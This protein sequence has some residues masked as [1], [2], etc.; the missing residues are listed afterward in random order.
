MIHKRRLAV[1]LGVCVAASSVAYAAPG[2]GQKD[3]SGGVVML[4]AGARTP[5]QGY[6]GV[7]IRDVGEEQVSALHLKD[8]RGAEIV[9]VDH[10]GPAGKAGL[11][12]RDVILQMNGQ[13]VEGA[14]PLR[15]MLRATT[16]GRV[17][18]FVICRDGQQQTL[19]A[20]LADR[21]VVER[22]AWEQHTTVPEPPQESDFA[23]FASGFFSAAQAQA[24]AGGGR[25]QNNLIATT[26]LSPS[27]T[28][29]ILETM[30]PQLAEFFGATGGAGLLVRSVDA[31]SPAAAAGM[32]A[33]DVVVRV[34]STPIA[35]GNDW[36]RTMHDSLGKTV[37]VVVLRDKREQTLTL[38]PDGKKRSAMEWEQS[39][40]ADDGALALSALLPLLQVDL[41][42]NQ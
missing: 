23:G 12:E 20:K 29:A 42:F 13:P 35:N 18:S 25:G 17:V 1:A 6:L 36:S 22:Q 14:E 30:G 10:D 15:Q 19:T 21:A 24:L 3:G 11:R 40:P 16:P 5:A 32:R 31:N 8:A 34:N 7:D 41:W 39:L 33:G 2:T 4:L 26:I 27:Y 9:Q 37:N 38:V 28:G